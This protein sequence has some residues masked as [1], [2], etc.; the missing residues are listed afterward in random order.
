[1][2]SAVWEEIGSGQAIACVRNTM[3]GY[4]V[5]LRTNQTSGSSYV[6]LCSTS[7]I[8]NGKDFDYWA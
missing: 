4:D 1:M 2:S 6:K 7:K 8:V 3:G 5:F